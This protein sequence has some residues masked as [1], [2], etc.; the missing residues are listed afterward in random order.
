[1]DQTGV[2]KGEQGLAFIDEAYAAMTGQTE[3]KLDPKAREDLYRAMESL[4]PEYEGYSLDDLI[5][6]MTALAAWNKFGKPTDNF[7]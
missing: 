2:L 5:R 4:N 1:M 3:V 7:E 6:T